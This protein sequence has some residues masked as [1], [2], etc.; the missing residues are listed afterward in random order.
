MNR[1][2]ILCA[3][4]ILVVAASFISAD[5]NK[6]THLSVTKS[7]STKSKSLNVKF[8]T[9]IA[10]EPSFGKQ[11]GIDPK[12]I[13]NKPKVKPLT[14][15]QHKASKD[16]VVNVVQIVIPSVSKVTTPYPYNDPNFKIIRKGT[17]PEGTYFELGVIQRPLQNNQQG[18]TGGVRR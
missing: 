5:E 6:N 15:E 17:T 8:T 2:S 1:I 10:F 16:R 13:P 9:K 12:N 11:L 4:V 14:P 18:N 7:P 3:S